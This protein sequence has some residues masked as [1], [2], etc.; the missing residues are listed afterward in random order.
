MVIDRRAA[1]KTLV[2]FRYFLV[3]L[4]VKSTFLA[5]QEELEALLWIC[6]ATRIIPALA[7]FQRVHRLGDFIMSVTS[8]PPPFF[9]SCAPSQNASD[10][11]GLECF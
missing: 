2:I 9:F 5:S 6:F 8:P 4:F 11:G 10:L 3:S 1:V 7:G